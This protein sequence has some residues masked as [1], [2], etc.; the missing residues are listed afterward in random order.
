LRVFAH[1]IDRGAAKLHDV[2]DGWR[3]PPQLHSYIGHGMVT[4]I[5]A[6]RL[7][8]LASKQSRDEFRL[9]AFNYQWCAPISKGNHTI[10]IY[11]ASAFGYFDEYLEAVHVFVDA[12]KIKNADSRCAEYATP[13]AATSPD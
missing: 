6:S 12:N 9:T 11:G 10:T 2:R 3:E 7:T 8:S 1:I 5:Q 4:F 13:N